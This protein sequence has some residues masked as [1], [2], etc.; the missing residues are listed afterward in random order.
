MY[1][2]VGST[3][4]ELRGITV[5]LVLTP[6][7]DPLMTERAPVLESMLK[8]E[9]VPSWMFG[10]YKN[11]PAGSNAIQFGPL[12]TGVGVLGTGV[13]FP[14]ESKEN[15]TTEALLELATNRNLPE[16]ETAARRGA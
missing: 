7:G 1:F 2:P 9:K 11:F 3:T 12:P 6:K 10:T 8:P 4:T 16:G 15:P 13:R 14:D 5:V